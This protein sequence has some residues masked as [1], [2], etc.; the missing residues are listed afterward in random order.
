MNIDQFWN[1]L[2][3]EEKNF[4]GCVLEGIDFYAEYFDGF[5]F[6]NAIFVNAKY[7]KVVS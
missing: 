6:S 4:Q 2:D 5:D 3:K 1:F 7:I